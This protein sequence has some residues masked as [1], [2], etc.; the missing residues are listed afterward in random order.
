M[1]IE[2]INLDYILIMKKALKYKNLNERKYK[3]QKC[4]QEIGRNLNANI[5]INIVFK[6]LKLYMENYTVI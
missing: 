6:G 4:G 2:H 5:N 1:S 3:C